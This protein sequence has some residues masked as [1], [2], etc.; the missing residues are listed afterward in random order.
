M[1]LPTLSAT[2]TPHTALPNMTT[3]R[4]VQAQLQDSWEKGADPKGAGH[5]GGTIVGKT[6]PCAET[7]VLE[8]VYYLKHKGWDVTSVYFD[9]VRDL[10]R[11]VRDY[12]VVDDAVLSSGSNTHLMSDKKGI[13]LQRLGHSR[14]ITGITYDHADD[15]VSLIVFDPRIKGICVMDETFLRKDVEGKEKKGWRIMLF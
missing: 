5:F 11:C 12:Y 4:D 3:V 6:G 10:L 13:Y 7:G 9:D 1:L 2:A 8:Y 15:G 14:L